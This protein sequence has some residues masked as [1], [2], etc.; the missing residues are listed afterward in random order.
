MRRWSLLWVLLMAGPLGAQE[1]PEGWVS[2]LDDPEA[3]AAGI[4]FVTMEP[5]WHVTTGPAAILYD[6][7]HTASGD[8]SVS[9]DIFLFDPE[10]RRE[11]FGVFIGGSDLEGPDQGYTYFLIRDGGEFLVKQRHGDVTTTV[12]DWEHHPEIR[13]FGER[14]VGDASVLNQLVVEVRG[15]ECRF[16]VNGAEVANLPAT[17]LSLDGVVGL[18]VNHAVNLH[19]S[20]LEI[21]PVGGDH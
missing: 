10:G 12:R 2:R 6:P 17:D 8:F 11:A 1:W 21:D 4:A 3:D 16:L 18:R 13:S 5:G 7:D 15:G 19:V 20:K 14:A 9:A